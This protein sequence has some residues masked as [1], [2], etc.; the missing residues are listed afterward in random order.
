ML[1]RRV[2]VWTPLRG[3]T[4]IKLSED[5]SFSCAPSNSRDAIIA[6]HGRQ[7][8]AVSVIFWPRRMHRTDAACCYSCRTFGGLCVLF[9]Y[10]ALLV[11][12]PAYIV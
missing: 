7:S 9:V 3:R 6:L 4:S 1:P 10:C 8:G 11:C 12:L 5:A 2:C